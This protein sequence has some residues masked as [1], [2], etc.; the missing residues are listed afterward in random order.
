MSKSAAYRAMDVARNVGE[1]L[2]KLGS[3]PLTMVQQIASK[4]TPEAAR[5]AIVERIDAGE[6]LAP[7]VILKL[8]HGAQA[9]A[10]EAAALGKLSP[11]QRKQLAAK[12]ARQ[13]R[14]KE[15][16]DGKWERN[17]AQAEEGRARQEGAAQ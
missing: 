12:Q 16:R 6:P 3:L 9:E 10:K 13:R 5:V 4:A 7:A 11:E 1:R 2:P 17:R 14:E 8:V 15:R